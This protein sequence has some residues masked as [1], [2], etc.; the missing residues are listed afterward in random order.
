MRKVK[1]L[2]LVFVTICFMAGCA[3]NPM[4]S[5]HDNNRK[6]ASNTNTCYEVTFVK[7]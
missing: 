1:F 2:S 6:I 7:R 5:V 4:V 3:S